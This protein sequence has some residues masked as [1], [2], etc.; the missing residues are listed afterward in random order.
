MPKRSSTE[1]VSR[2]RKINRKSRVHDL[3]SKMRVIDGENVE[4]EEDLEILRLEKLL[5]IKKG[6]PL[7][8]PLLLK[9]LK[10]FL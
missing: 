10:N 2:L 3:R 7:N 4:N 5:G 9:F 8:L 6:L 1:T